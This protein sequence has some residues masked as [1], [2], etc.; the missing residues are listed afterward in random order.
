MTTATALLVIA[1]AGCTAEITSSD[2]ARVADQATGA[3]DSSA[4][5][6]VRADAPLPAADA[7]GVDAPRADSAPPDTSKPPPDTSNLPPD[8][9]K[10]PPDT[11]NA[12]G[13]NSNV[14]C[15]NYVCIK[16]QCV[17]DPLARAFSGEAIFVKDQSGLGSA[18]NMHFPSVQAVGSTLYAFY[19][20]NV[21]VAGVGRSRI[22]L[23]TSTDAKTFV[24]QGVALDIGGAWETVYDAKTDLAHQLGELASDGW[25]ADVT[26]HNKGFL[27]YGP[28]RTFDPLVAQI[29]SFRMLVDY[30]LDHVQV[31]NI[32]VYDATANA[33]VAQRTLYRDD[34]AAAWAY[35]IF[36]LQLAPQAGHRYEFRV[37]WH[38]TT[39]T[40]VSS[41]SLSSGKLPLWDDR[42]AS[43][44]GVLALGSTWYVA[45]EG[46]SVGATSPG[47]VG[48]VTSTDPKR[49]T[50]S[51]AG[52]FLAHDSS[53]WEGTNIGTPSLHAEGN[54][55]YLYYHGFDGTDVQ[56][57]LAT[58]TPGGAPTKYAG[59]PIL[60]TSSSGWDSGTVGK[61]SRIF[62]ENGR[63]YMAYEGSTEQPFNTARWAT[64]LARS[65]DLRSWQKSAINPV[66]AQTSG[67]FGN[68]GPELVLFQGR[69]YL[70]VRVGGS[71]TRYRLQGR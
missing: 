45:Y 57:G 70:Y 2:D 41:V 39:Y 71:T 42:L 8:A 43:F 62:K 55:I 16:G 30:N 24:K 34:F 26:R 44:P 59:N 40:R 49:F 15:A 65:S 19:I 14:D 17:S 5:R 18:F 63:Y 58:F 22:G 61:R 67:G 47:D 56:I 64:G 51:R 53:G 20:D 50:R 69:Y 1:L 37:Y 11:G 25:A 7:L 32:E 68:D 13:C 28:Y 48:L 60:R 33:V 38:D 9:S 12:S 4:A 52:P 21:I 54:T 23:A 27:I 10:P 66:V 35:Q 31:A 3:A 36:N 29:V 46:A 6:D